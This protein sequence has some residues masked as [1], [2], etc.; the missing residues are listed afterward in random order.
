MRSESILK[1][2]FKVN[3]HFKMASLSSS[4]SREILPKLCQ[5]AGKL[6]GIRGWLTNSAY[7]VSYGSEVLIENFLLDEFVSYIAYDY[8]RFALASWESFCVAD[9]ES[10]RHRLAGWPLLKVYYSGFFA[11]HAIM[12]ALGEAVVQLDRK[13]LTC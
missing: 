2:G 1:T 13:T 10:S 9:M 7:Q 5:S 4:L 12:R 8:E 6:D 11:A 3:C